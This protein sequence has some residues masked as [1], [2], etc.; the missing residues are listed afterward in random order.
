MIMPNVLEKGQTIYGANNKLFKLSNGNYVFSEVY[1]Y[2]ES[3]DDYEEEAKSCDKRFLV[4]GSPI[5]WKCTLFDESGKLIES[6]R[7]YEPD[8]FMD[9]TA[10]DAV[11]EFIESTY[12]ANSGITFE[13]AT[14]AECAISD[15]VELKIK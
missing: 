4:D 6:E 8:N 7:L 11:E 14:D 3:D 5:D 13:V 12:G 15:P 9:M 10:E 1:L 2:S